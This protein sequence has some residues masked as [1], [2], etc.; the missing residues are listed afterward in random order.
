M[1]KALSGIIPSTLFAITMLILTLYSI[2]MFTSSLSSMLR[3]ANSIRRQEHTIIINS[4][5]VS[6]NGTITL[7]IYNN[8]A[9]TIPNIF[10]LDIVV[11]CI[12]SKVG[13]EVTYVLKPGVNWYV[14]KICISNS[15]IC[16]NTSSGRVSLKPGEVAVLRGMLDEAPSLGSWGSVAVITST[17]WRAER[18]FVMG[19]AYEQN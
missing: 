9:I 17:G 14:E 10:E 13:K 16:F 4:V 6:A 2:H 19:V 3:T 12:D 7:A 5:A 1:A 11:T 8:G 18:A 15:D